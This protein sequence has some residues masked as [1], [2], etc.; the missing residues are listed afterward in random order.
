[1]CYWVLPMSYIPIARSTTNP[2]QTAYT[3]DSTIQTQAACHSN[4]E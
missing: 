3:R 1:M 2:I 4:L